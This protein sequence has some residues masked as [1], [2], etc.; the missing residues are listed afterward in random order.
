MVMRGT[1]VT[2]MRVTPAALAFS[3]MSCKDAWRVGVV[4]LLVWSL[5]V[6]RFVV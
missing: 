5:R 2:S 6:Q 1:A 3:Q 4:G